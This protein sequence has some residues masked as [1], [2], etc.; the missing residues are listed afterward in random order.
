M[1]GMYLLLNIFYRQKLLKGSA[2][3]P[4]SLA[5]RKISWSGRGQRRELSQCAVRIILEME[6]RTREMGSVSSRS[7]LSPYWRRLWKLRVPRCI[8]LFLWRASNDILPTKHNLFRKK[9]VVDPLCPMCGCVS[10]TSAHVLWACDA[11]RA[12]WGLCGGPIQK[13]SLMVDNFFSIFCYLCNRLEDS[14][15][16]LFAML[17][18]KIWICRNRLVFDGLVLP[19][20]CL[21]KGA[22]E[23]LEEFRNSLGDV[24]TPMMGAIVSPSQWSAPVVGNIK[25]NWDAAVDGLRGVELWLLC[26]RSCPISE[27]RL[28]LKQLWLGGLS[29]LV[30][31]WALILLSWKVMQGKWFWC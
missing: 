21:L 23:D 10:E 9:V 17:A 16:E 1:G 11:A 6:R 13:S 2:V 12:V 24:V 20:N 4:L 26:V 29:N 30:G 5:L 14:E 31:R 8:I 22:I 19:P 15:L 7:D 3:S 18:H 28:R 25:I 27:T